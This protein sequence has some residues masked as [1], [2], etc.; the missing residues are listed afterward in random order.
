M[1]IYIRNGAIPGIFIT[2]G[3]IDFRSPNSYVQIN[4]TTPLLIT[5][6]THVGAEILLAISNVPQH[7]KRRKI[8]RDFGG[9]FG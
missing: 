4:D 6:D 3:I 2:N 5:V 8:S 1:M 7:P 9:H